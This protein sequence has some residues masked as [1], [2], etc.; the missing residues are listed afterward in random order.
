MKNDLIKPW[1]G[2]NHYKDSI[3]GAN[4]YF[5]GVPS[6][7]DCVLRYV[8]DGGHDD[9]MAAFAVQ[10]WPIRLADMYGVSGPDTIRTDVNGVL[11]MAMNFRKTGRRHIHNQGFGGYFRCIGTYYDG[12]MKDFGPSDSCKIIDFAAGDIVR[13]GSTKKDIPS[14]VFNADK[15]IAK[16]T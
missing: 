15:M 8:A 9:C 7:N 14:D 5:A 12:S 3:S 16:F 6:G 13:L 4:K 10:V 1:T 2:Y 11:Q